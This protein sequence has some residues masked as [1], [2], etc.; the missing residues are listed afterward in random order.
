LI[1]DAN[2]ADAL[3]PVE[4]NLA[5]PNVH[6]SYTDR[7]V[8]KPPM[9]IELHTRR[10]WNLLRTAAVVNLLLWGAV[11]LSTDLSSAGRLPQVV[12]SGVYTFVCAFRSCYPRIDLER[13]VLR[14]HWLSSIVL[15]RSAATIAEMCFTLQLALILLQYADE[16]PWLRMVAWMTP[17]FTVCVWLSLG[18]AK[19][20]P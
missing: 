14:D 6:P 17:Y 7:F 16:V 12:L 5:E 4:P 8:N 9:I 19:F 2:S 15:G 18:L 13:I 1:R 3:N 10:W 20:G 11:V